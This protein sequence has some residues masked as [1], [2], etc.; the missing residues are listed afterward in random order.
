VE[1]AAIE[2]IIREVIDEWKRTDPKEYGGWRQHCE[3]E[4]RK[5]IEGGWTKDRSMMMPL[6]LPS[7]PV[8]VIGRRLMDPLWWRHDEK[9]LETFVRIM[10][11][12]RMNENVG[13]RSSVLCDGDRQQTQ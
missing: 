10:P 12:C 4:R 13:F 1:G 5:K 2:K 8:L 11:C 7:W 3:D 9:A 6:I